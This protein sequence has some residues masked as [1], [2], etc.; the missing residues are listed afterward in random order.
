LR[1]R[2]VSRSAIARV[3]ASRVGSETKKAAPDDDEGSGLKAKPGDETG[4]D[5]DT[6]RK[7][8]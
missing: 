5:D 6:T 2:T 7:S 1:T 4:V 3:H 8:A